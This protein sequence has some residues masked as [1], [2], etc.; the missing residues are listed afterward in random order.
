MVPAELRN[1]VAWAENTRASRGELLELA[2]HCT[3]AE[4]AERVRERL[5]DPAVA[6]MTALRLLEAV[7]ESGGKVATRRR[8]E[9]ADLVATV[10]LG[11]L[12]PSHWERLDP[13][14]GTGGP[15]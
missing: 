3:V 1:A 13:R 14:S 6:T 8:F 9:A 5:S 12:G 4:L 2:R 11:Q 10:A 15:S 7:P